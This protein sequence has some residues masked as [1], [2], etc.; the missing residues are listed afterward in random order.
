[1]KS[2]V[3]QRFIVSA[4]TFVDVFE[5]NFSVGHRVEISNLPLALT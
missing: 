1:L 4:F 2:T 5:I 3:A